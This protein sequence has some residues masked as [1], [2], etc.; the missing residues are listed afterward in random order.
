M[1][2]RR[3]SLRGFCSVDGRRVHGCMEEAA[4]KA[5]LLNKMLNCCM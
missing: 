5:H 1:H 4:A 2:D 3:P